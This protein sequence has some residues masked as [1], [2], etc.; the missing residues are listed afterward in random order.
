ME[1]NFFQNK[2]NIFLII[3]IVVLL[4]LGAYFYWQS[5]NSVVYIDQAQIAAPTVNLTSTNGGILKQTFVTEGEFVKVNTLIA[6]IDKELIKTKTAGEVIMLNDSL[7]TSITK[8]AVVATVI[9]PNGFEVSGKL[10][11]NK[12][13][14]Y[15]E[16][17]KPAYFTVDTYGSKK[18]YGIVSEVSPTSDVASLTFS[19]S[20]KRETKNFVVKIDFNYAQYPELKNGMSAKIWVAK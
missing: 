15:V 7:G 3:I 1:K 20:D 16:V 5:T 11:E 13:L 6:R 19:I 12:G 10:A 8:G 9:D 17:G 18:F 2:T 4:G 14:K